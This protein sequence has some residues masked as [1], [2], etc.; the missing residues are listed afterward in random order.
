MIFLCF[1][2]FHRNTQS[3]I[4]S[5]H[6][7]PTHNQFYRPNIE[8]P[9]FDPHEFR[10]LENLVIAWK[11][12]CVLENFLVFRWKNFR[13]S[14]NKCFTRKSF[15]SLKFLLL[16]Y[17]KT[18]LKINIPMYLHLPDA[19]ARLFATTNNFSCVLAPNQYSSKKNP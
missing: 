16:K 1:L 9:H 4:W 3:N 8:F 7:A 11:N 14:I 19:L 5:S 17:I 10:V 18:F 15:C 2:V 6:Q 13:V 12:F